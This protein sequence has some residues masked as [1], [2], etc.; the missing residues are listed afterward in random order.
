ME[1]TK[2]TKR[3][4]ASTSYSVTSSLDIER[5]IDVLTLPPGSLKEDADGQLICETPHFEF[6]FAL[7]CGAEIWSEESF[8]QEREKI[9]GTLLDSDPL[10]DGLVMGDSTFLG[11]LRMLERAQKTKHSN[12]EGRASSLFSG[13][14]I[15]YYGKWNENEKKDEDEDEDEDENKDEDEDE[16][17]QMSEGSLFDTSSNSDSISL[18]TKSLATN[19]TESQFVKLLC[20]T[21]PMIL[22]R[23]TN[24]STKTPFS[25]ISKTKIILGP[26]SSP[27]DLISCGDVVDRV[28][29][30]DSE[31]IEIVGAEWIVDS[32]RD[33]QVQ[34]TSRFVK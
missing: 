21:S 18:A 29:I 5:G 17:T 30:L 33:G 15:F 13:Y 7:A 19:M 25:A 20:R 24:E 12:L 9:P 34:D 11:A 16:E 23:L 28:W 14:H 31:D 27:S 2:L 8:I 22:Q 10:P 32:I 3:A 1:P 4:S 6:L 26:K